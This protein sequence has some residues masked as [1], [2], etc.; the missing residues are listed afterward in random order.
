MKKK[1]VEPINHCLFFK[2]LLLLFCFFKIPNNVCLNNNTKDMKEAEK[3]ERRKGQH[4]VKNIF[5]YDKGRHIQTN[6]G[7]ILLKNPASIYSQHNLF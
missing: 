4:E 6:L 7:A 1:Q 3:S 5:S 2:P